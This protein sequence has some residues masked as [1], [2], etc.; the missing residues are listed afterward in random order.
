MQNSISA[1]LFDRFMLVNRVMRKNKAQEC[2]RSPMAH[3]EIILVILYKRGVGMKQQDIAGEIYV[4]KSTLSEMIDRLVE[5][6]S[7]ERE[8]DPQDRRSTIVVLTERGKRRAEEVMEEHAKA[9]EQLFSKL[10]EEEKKTL[11]C[12]LEKLVGSDAETKEEEK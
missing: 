10:S 2:A 6:G 1:A 8:T 9:V 11:L 3:R 12:L 7:L 4:S 5:D